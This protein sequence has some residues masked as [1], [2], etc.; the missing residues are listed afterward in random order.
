M[1]SHGRGAPHYA[2]HGSHYAAHPAHGQEGHFASHGPAQGHG[3]LADHN[4]IHGANRA[5]Q[6]QFAHNQP[7]R[8]QVTHNQ[9]IAQHFQGLN[10]FN[11][12]GFNRNGFGSNTDWNHWGGQFWGAGWDNWGGGW[13]GWAGPVFWPFVLG[14]VVS[15]VLWPY[16]Y[17]AFWA[18]GPDFVLASIFAPGPF[19]GVEYGYGL[20]YYGYGPDHGYTGGIPNIYYYNAY[21]YRPNGREQRFATTNKANRQALA[22]TN[23]EAV[24]SCSSLA[25]GVMNLPIERIRQTIHPTGDQQAVLDGLS[26]AIDQAQGIIAT[27]CPSAVP[28]TPIGRLDTAEQRLEVTIRAI[29]I[30]RPAL[31]KFYES[32]NDEQK[33]KFNQMGSSEGASSGGDLAALCSRQ[34]EGAVN[35]PAQRIQQVVAPNAQEQSAFDDLKKTA[36]KAADQLR[37]SCPSA[38]PR[39]PVARLD[40]VETRLD[41]MLGAIK[42]IRPSLGNFYGSLTDEQK[43]R[44]NTMGPPPQTVSSQP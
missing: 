38:V 44:F 5:A 16:D 32:L 14:D 15:F 40:A 39:S 13:G 34:A 8:N 29:Q 27:S 37:S 12:T 41:S 36:Q 35:V 28:L 17:D 43:A 6:R 9:F 31:E 7:G 3:T 11:R 22:E 2:R 18:Y 1:A 4:Q 42:S 24:Q 26:A 20:D 10:N 19:L 30:V 25:P 21:R 33:S 23:H